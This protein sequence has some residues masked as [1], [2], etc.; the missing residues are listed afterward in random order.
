MCVP[1]HPGSHDRHQVQIKFAGRKKFERIQCPWFQNTG[2]ARTA[3]GHR[4][5][6]PP[7]PRPFFE[8]PEP[9]WLHTAAGCAASGLIGSE[10][11]RAGVLVAALAMLPGSFARTY[12]EIFACVV[13]GRARSHAARRCGRSFSCGLRQEKNASHP[14][15]SVTSK[16]CLS[17]HRRID[18][19]P[20]ERRGP[21]IS[22]RG[23]VGGE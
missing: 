1:R 5:P 14:S 13:R 18:A 16:F 17:P 3:P 23:A 22:G 21:R 19:I 6:P 15:Y 11:I 8:R 7:S 20:T 10:R 4:G 9:R 2:H 12:A